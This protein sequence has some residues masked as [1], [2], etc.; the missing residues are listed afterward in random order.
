MIIST[1]CD[2]AKLAALQALCPP[3]DTYRLALYE[4]EADIG[5]DT[6]RYTPKNEC[7]G[8]GYQNGGKNL[9]GYRCALI[10]G[11]ACLTFEPPAWDKVTVSTAGCM[12]YNASKN[13]MAIAVI[14]FGQEFHPHNGEFVPE[15]PAF[16]AQTAMIYIG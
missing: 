14:A 3:G 12:I 13:N 11:V 4:V 6:P 16:T 10:D 1:F 9:F 8:A 5:P 2:N 15:F 7:K